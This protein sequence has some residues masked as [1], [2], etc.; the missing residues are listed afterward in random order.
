[1]FSISES[2]RYSK[3]TQI[4]RFFFLKFGIIRQFFCG[5]SYSSSEWWSYEEYIEDIHITLRERELKRLC[6]EYK[7]P[8]IEW[9]PHFVQ[10]ILDLVQSHNLCHSTLHLG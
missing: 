3:T 7:A 8:Q 1:M 10:I 2:E 9:R 4:L 6:F 5:F